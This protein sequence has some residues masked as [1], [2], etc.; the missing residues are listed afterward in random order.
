MQQNENSKML[1]QG[2]EGDIEFSNVSFKY[3]SR[4]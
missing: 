2:I 1:K 4:N 3:D